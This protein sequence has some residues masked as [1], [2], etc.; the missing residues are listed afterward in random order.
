MNLLSI[1]HLSKS[2]SRRQL[3]DDTSFFLQEGEKVGIIGINGTGK[4][5]L[6]K[7]LYF[8]QA[9]TSG[10]A[11]LSLYQDGQKNI[12]EASSQQKSKRPSA[13]VPDTAPA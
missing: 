11:Y 13:T 1:E 7:T 3:F 5:T 6:L 8:D 9:A 2:Y 10:G 4:S 12:L